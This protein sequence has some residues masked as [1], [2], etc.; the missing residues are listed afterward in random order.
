MIDTLIEQ[1]QRAAAHQQPLKIRGSGSKDFY[2]GASQGTTLDVSCHTG[3]IDYAPSELVITARAGTPLKEIEQTLSAQSQMLAFEPPYFG[4]NAT[5]GGCI[6][7]GL[8][9]PRRPYSGAVRDFVLGVNM[10]DGCGQ[11]LKSAQSPPR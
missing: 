2:G 9:G 7:S 10:L 8:S 4:A 1:I 3:I 6:A 11:Q 5:L